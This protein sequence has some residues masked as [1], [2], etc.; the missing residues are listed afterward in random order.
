[1]TLGLL[2]SNS[3]R[4]A[5]TKH[6]HAIAA[7]RDAITFDIA[8][9]SLQ[10]AIASASPSS[11][12]Q[13]ATYTS[14]VMGGIRTYGVALPPG[15]NQ[16]PAQHYPVIFLLH[17]GGMGGPA[18]WFVD[19]KAVTTLKHLYREGKLPPSI[20]ITPNGHDQRPP[21][22]GLDSDYI[23]GPNGNVSTAIGQELVDVVR[24]RYRTLPNPDFWAI[25][26]LSSGGWGAIN[27]GLH[28]TQQF[29]VLFSHSGYFED[30]SGPEN[31]PMAF[32]KTL[33]GST[34]QHLHIYLDVGNL[35]HRFLQ[36]TQ[37]F[38]Q[39]LNQLQVNNTC[40][41]FPGSHSW[42][43]WQQ[44]LADSLT[45]VGEQFKTQL[46]HRGDRSTIR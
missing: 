15:Y 3:C 23:D 46:V 32:I 36:Q 24:Q 4:F 18:V 22:P 44:H 31:S 45:F 29:S 33:P 21:K 19:G 38:H 40:N 27:V 14:T 42:R 7:L 26:G 34:L 16:H 25:G 12:Y 35:D 9:S 37:E 1:M 17:G 5:H 2:L 39:V 8:T 30:K 13:I 10:A 41:I 43:F 28:H 11:G 20:V 6:A